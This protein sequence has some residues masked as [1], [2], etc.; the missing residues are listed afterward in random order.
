MENILLH[1]ITAFLIFAGLGVGLYSLAGSK[2]KDEQPHHARRK[3]YTGGEDL[4]L[5]KGQVQYQAF[6][7][8][9]LLFGILHMAA[10]VLS[11][12]PQEDIPFLLVLLYL[13]GV[14][15]SVYVLSEEGY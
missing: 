1:P 4:P 7:W 14:S 6:F 5:P 15:A 2:S 8:M 9:A 13:V 10:L 11:T 12:L 3:P